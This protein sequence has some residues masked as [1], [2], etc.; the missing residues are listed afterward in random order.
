M[1]LYG[2]DTAQLAL[3]SGLV[4]RTENRDSSIEYLRS[5]IGIQD[6]GYPN[7]DY[8]G[9]LQSQQK[10]RPLV[11]WSPNASKAAAA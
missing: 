9:Y 10:L 6:E 2:G 7:V 8:A 1:A 3:Q 4:D 5:R 11:S